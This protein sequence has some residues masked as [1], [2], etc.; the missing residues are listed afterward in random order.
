MLHIVLRVRKEEEGILV[1][2]SDLTTKTW[3]EPR[4]LS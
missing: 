3:R 2:I 4:P 1:R